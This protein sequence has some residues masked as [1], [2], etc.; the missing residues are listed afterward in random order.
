MEKKTI[1][2]RIC[3]VVINL[4]F[5]FAGFIGTIFGMLFMSPYPLIN[6]GQDVEPKVQGG[7]FLCGL[8]L[9]AV[10]IVVPVIANLLLY[11]F[12]YSKCTLSKKWIYIPIGIITVG[13]LI[14]CVITAADYMN[15]WV[16]AIWYW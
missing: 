14:I 9:I 1:I 5:A 3:S 2:A 6:F 13:L 16:N 4:L 11:R 12:W 7:D 10:S 8:F 15:G